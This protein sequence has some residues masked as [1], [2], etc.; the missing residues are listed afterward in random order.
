MDAFSGKFKKIGVNVTFD[1]HVE[2]LQPE[3][4]SIG[5][6][7]R[8]YHGVYLQADGGEIVIGSKS[9]FAPYSVLY[10]PLEIGGDAVCRHTPCSPASGISTTI[11]PSRSP[12]AP[13]LK[14][15]LSSRIMSGSGQTQ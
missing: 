6:N 3:F 5:D 2:I 7:V 1:E 15:R 8:F 11:R 12:A 13:A 9:H 10:G 14:R 4:I